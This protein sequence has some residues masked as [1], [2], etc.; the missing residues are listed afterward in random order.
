[1]DDD[2]KKELLETMGEVK[3]IKDSEVGVN[4]TTEALLLMI[5]QDL[6]TIR[7]NQG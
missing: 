3:D 2:Y 5:Y 1:M 6:D 7:S 4:S